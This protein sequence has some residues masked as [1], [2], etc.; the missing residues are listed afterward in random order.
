MRRVLVSVLS[1]ALLGGPALAQQVISVKSGMVHYVQGD[2]KLDGKPVEVRFGQ[3]MFDSIKEGGVLETARGRAEVL[4]SP[5]M[6]IRLGE[7]TSLRM[8]NPAL[9]DTR[10]EL[11]SGS[12]LLEVSDIDKETSVAVRLKDSTVVPRKAGLYRLDT[13]PAVL[14]VYEGRADVVS[15][16]KTVDVK[17][18]KM[19]SLDGR[20]EMSKFDTD[21][22]D[23]LHRWSGRRARYLALANVSAAR[24]VQRR[25]MGWASSGWLWNPYFGM[26]TYIPV[27]GTI[28]SP[29]GYAFYSPLMVYRVYQPRPVYSAGGGGFGGGGNSGFTPRY[30]SNLGYSTVGS[31]SYG[32]YSGSTGSS[33][34]SA[35]AAASAPAAS[36]RRAPA[37]S[38]RGE[39]GG[40]R[41]Q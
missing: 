37:A 2:V 30:D 18:G 41:S 5:G 16:D 35:P 10:L 33:V 38:G 25:G 32:G 11:L 36:P 12:A 23:S 14:R 26:Y 17:K 20:M 31:R 39:T 6:I 34:S 29:W 4:L 21:R 7:D 13:D 22:G 1:A 8:V 19:L 24:S 28:Y 27:R 15:G 9:V 3:S 40:G